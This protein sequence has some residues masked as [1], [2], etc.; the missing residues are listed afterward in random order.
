MQQ[1]Q[2]QSGHSLKASLLFYNKTKD[3]KQKKKQQK[4]FHTVDKILINFFIIF[5]Q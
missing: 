1:A 3:R 2:A 5:S 4:I